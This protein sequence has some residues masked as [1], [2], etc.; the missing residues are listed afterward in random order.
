LS[1]LSSIIPEI[2]TYPPRATNRYHTLYRQF[3]FLEENI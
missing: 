3:S 1:I 2:L